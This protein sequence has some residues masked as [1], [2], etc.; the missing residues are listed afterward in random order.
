[1]I[2]CAIIG[3]KGYIGRHVEWFLK[4]NG[5]VPISY[6]IE[7]SDDR[8]CIHVDLTDKM[9]VQRISLDVDFVF[10]ISGLSGTYS[11]FDLYEQ[12]VSI[13][14]IGLLNVLD[15]IRRSPYRP[16]VVFPSSRLVYKGVD[17][18]LK[19]DDRKE[20]KTIYAVNKLACEGILE[21]YG[22]SFDIPYTIFRI[23]VP[24]GNIFDNNYSYGTVGFFIKMASAGNDISIYGDGSLKRTFTYIEDLC[25]QLVYGV[26]NPYSEGE[27][28]NISGET[29]TLI[30]VATHISIK[31]GVDVTNK[32]WP[33]KD[34][35][36]ESGHT[37]FDDS[38]IKSLLSELKIHT[39]EDWLKLV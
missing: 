36:I 30:E 28:Y 37:Y 9:S 22:A 5:I 35:R 15:A 29:L 31:Y 11:G 33:D 27:T 4:K 7:C 18:P 8:E 21:A 13:N 3:S 19:E 17:R 34:F 6:D 16:R 25:Q 10:Y 39:L 14:E 32:P 1:M 23:G 20:T 24:Y 2:K 26:F 38:K 12:Y